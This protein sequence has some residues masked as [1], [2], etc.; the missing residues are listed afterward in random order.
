M[1]GELF[2]L[3]SLEGLVAGVDEAGRGPLAGD[4]IAAAVILDPERPIDGLADSKK[5][6]DKSRENLYRQILASSLGVHV[7][8]AS[9]AEIDSLNILHATML[10]MTRAVAGLGNRPGHVLV[11]GNRLPTWNYCA[12]AV[13]GGDATVA[14]ISAASIVAK[15]T[16]DR[17]M[18]ELDKTYPAYGFADHKGYGTR[19]HLQALRRFGPSPV[20]RMSFRP[21]REWRTIVI[22]EVG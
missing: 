19:R 10:A 18:R 8:R 12:T 4:V 16:R 11:D 22:P 13:V 9:V 21:V 2:S 6:T 17:E 15:V 7:S 14:A 5:L 3:D 1:T 20:H